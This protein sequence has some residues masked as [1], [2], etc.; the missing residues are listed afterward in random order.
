MGPLQLA[1]FIGLDTCLEIMRV[2]FASTGDSKYRPAPLLTQ[3]CRGRLARAQDRQGVL[4]LRGRGTGADAVTLPVAAKEIAMTDRLRPSG[5]RTSA[6]Q[7]PEAAQRRAGR[8]ARRRRRRVADEALAGGAREASPL[9]SVKPDDDGEVM[10]N[11]TQDLIDKMRD[12]EQS[13]RIDMGAYR[14]EPNHDDEEDKY[15]DAADEDE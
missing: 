15:G 14:G 7:A 11:S 13:G 12:M 1:D 5:E 8:R 4:R 2:I 9:D 6:E 10:D 3:I